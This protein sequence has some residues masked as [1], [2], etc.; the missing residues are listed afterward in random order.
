MSTQ[1]LVVKVA[2]DN[3]QAQRAVQTL[4]RG[5]DKTLDDASRNAADLNKRIGGIG[6]DL[7][8][9]AGT[10]SGTS[11]AFGAVKQGA[12]E[13]GKAVGGAVGG[14]AGAMI[15]EQ[16]AEQTIER[17]QAVMEALLPKLLANVDRYIDARIKSKA[18]ELSG[19]RLN[20]I[21]AAAEGRVAALDVAQAVVRQRAEAGVS[22]SD[23]EVRALMRTI[24]RNTERGAQ[25]SAR[26]RDLWSESFWLDNPEARTSGRIN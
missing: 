20:D 18:N 5:L 14:P 8:R 13:I 7:V 4:G 15:G 10:G 26:V 19:G 21:E 6:S 23:E 24:A 1:D 25:A 2:L 16:I 12:G 9:G 11:A 3:S 22:T 17:I